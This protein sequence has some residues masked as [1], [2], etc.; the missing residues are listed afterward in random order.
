MLKVKAHTNQRPKRPQ[1][2][3]VS[4]ACIGVLLLPPGCGSGGGGS[5]SDDDDDGD[6]DAYVSVQ[7]L[8][9]SPKK[10]IA[11]DGTYGGFHSF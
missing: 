4:L 7:V 11:C 3:P 5:G 8:T 6:S 9:C 2:T 1:L 10:T